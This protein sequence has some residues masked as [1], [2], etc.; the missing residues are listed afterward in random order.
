M[1]FRAFPG[2]KTKMNSVEQFEA[3]V[4]EYYEPLF[5][6][7]MSL[8]RTES[9][10]RDLT[11]QT[12]YIWATKGHQVRD[13]SKAKTWLFTTLHRTFLKARQR[14]TRFPHHELEE[15]TDQ[16][17]SL[18]PEQA[19]RVDALQ[20]L[21]AL[22]KVDET[23]QAALALFYLD[24]CSYK[25]I[26]AILEVPIG[27]VKSRIARGILQ[28]RGILLSDPHEKP[29]STNSGTSFI[30]RLQRREKAGTMWRALHSSAL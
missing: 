22:A 13:Q 29:V 17:P 24:D 1:S 23:Y 16:L 10:A 25:E 18:G 2:S 3:L 20:V 4:S 19:I 15:V 8:S 5:R 21:P 28:L 27:T 7:A 30:M 12:F 6:F 11:Q 9:D 26:A 14:Q